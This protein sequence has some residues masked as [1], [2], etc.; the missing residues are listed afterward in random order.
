MIQAMVVEAKRN[1]HVPLPER[2]HARL[3]RESARTG[4]PATAIARDAI[5]DFLRRSRKAALH[6]AIASY[7]SRRAG[8]DDDLDSALEA[9][10]VDLL[11]DDAK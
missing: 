4:R 5:V 9:A 1:F 3:R 2:E 11:P 8:T 7:A 10:G 6:E